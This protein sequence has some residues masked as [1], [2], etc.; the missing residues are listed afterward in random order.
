[1]GRTVAEMRANAA[2]VFQAAIAAVDPE[3]A[4]IS[5]LTREKD[6]LYLKGKHFA[7]Q[8]FRRI[9][10]VGAG[11]AT[12]PMAGAMERLLGDRIDTGII[13]V[14]YGYSSPLQKVKVEEGGHPIPDDAGLKGARDIAHLL[15]QCDDNDLV[16]SLISGGGSALLPLP[17]PNVT[18]EQ[19]QVVTRELL[20]CGATIHELNA[21]RKHLSL[22]KGGGLAR[23]AYPATI[24]NL[25]LS[26]VVGD[27]MDVVASGP[28]VP[29]RSTFQDAVAVLEKYAIVGAIPRP[30]MDH[31]L[32]GARGVIPETPKKGDQIFEKV[33]NLVIGS[34]IIACTAAREQAKSLG[35]NTIILS[36]MI[37]GNTSDIALAHVAIAKEVLSS[38]NPIS[39]P[40]CIISGGETTVRVQGKGLGGRNQE[41]ALVCARSLVDLSG[42]IVI[43]SGGT[44]GTDGPTNAAGGIVDTGTLSRGSEMGLSVDSFLK[45]NDAYHYLQATGDLLMT[46]PMRTNVM[47]VRIM[48]VSD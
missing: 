19:K 25:M 41:F 23:H 45:N 1:M 15:S 26:D 28:F 43:L 22:T 7:L 9:V 48:L 31:L 18:L 12:A 33:T 6:T 40:A 37:E 35:Y 10:I 5:A 47:D 4:I 8:A 44:D 36:S 21:V 29:D 20:H 34:N 17:P 2:S 13:V 32:Q 24:I 16:I 46:G 42:K 38:H 39:R 27:D 3:A 11:K 30:I 14:K